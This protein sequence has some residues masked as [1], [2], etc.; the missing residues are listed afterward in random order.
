MTI[1]RAVQEFGLTQFKTNVIKTGK[2]FEYILAKLHSMAPSKTLIETAKGAKEKAKETALEATEKAK[3]PASQ[4][5]PKQQ[6]QLV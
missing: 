6:L 5:S 4:G 3:D 2:G 1:S